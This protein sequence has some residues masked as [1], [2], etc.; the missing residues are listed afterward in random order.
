MTPSGA[1]AD[2][3]DLGRYIGK[4]HQIKAIGRVST[5]IKRDPQEI[6]DGMV[7]FGKREMDPLRR[8]KSAEGMLI[9]HL[10]GPEFEEDKRIDVLVEML[11][12]DPQDEQAATF[13]KLPSLTPSQDQG[14]RNV[15]NELFQCA[16]PFLRFA[17]ARIEAEFDQPLTTALG[18]YD[19]TTDNWPLNRLV[20][21][22]YDKIQRVST[23]DPHAI[24]VM[25]VRHGLP[26][27]SLGNA[28][29]YKANYE[30][31][32]QDKQLHTRREHMNVPDLF[33]LAK[34]AVE[35]QMAVALGCVLLRP[36]AST[37]LIEQQPETGLVYRYEPQG[38]AP[39][40]VKLGKDKIGACIVLQQNPDD[41]VRLSQQIDQAVIQLARATPD[42]N[43][44]VIK[45]LEDYI[46][47]NERQLEEWE[48]S[49]VSQYVERLR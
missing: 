26:L 4:M 1:E 2:R 39:V 28:T 13:F 6:V 27:N 9:V 42:G 24:V 5:W 30:R 7:E 38:R 16:S 49:M 14:L 47:A 12:K 31:Y 8:R 20:T 23:G 43:Q 35:P 29:R 10:R 11:S 48:L 21:T 37:P 32:F 22:Y 36:G 17:K 40:D 15:A 3:T 33:P 46:R 18:T 34:D 45:Q 25:S 41:L 44:V 19:A